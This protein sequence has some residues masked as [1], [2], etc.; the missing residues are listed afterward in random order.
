MVVLAQYWVLSGVKARLGC[1]M[2][3]YGGICYAMVIYMVALY[4][5]APNQCVLLH[6]LLI[7]SV[8]MFA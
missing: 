8:N 3:G 1:G 6:L 4:I 7:A 5:D 2:G